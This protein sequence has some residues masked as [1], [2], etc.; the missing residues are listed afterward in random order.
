MKMLPQ[1]I[2]ARNVYKVAQSNESST[3]VVGMKLRLHLTR[4]TALPALV[5]FSYLLVG[6]TKLIN[7]LI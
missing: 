6:L 4:T 3:K 7:E 5:F 2:I 1:Y